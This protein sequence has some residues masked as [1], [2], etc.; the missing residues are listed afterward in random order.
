MIDPNDIAPGAALPD[1]PQRDHGGWLTAAER[2]S[3]AGDG[4]LVYL[5]ACWIEPPGPTVDREQVAYRLLVP[6][7]GARRLGLSADPRRRAQANVLA[8]D[9]ERHPISGPYQL[10]LEAFVSRDQRAGMRCDLVPAIA[11]TGHDVS[12]YTDEPL[13]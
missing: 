11:P 5:T 7:G 2:D 9:L 3:M 4:L 8:L 1:R 10:R 6:N 12:A 13:A